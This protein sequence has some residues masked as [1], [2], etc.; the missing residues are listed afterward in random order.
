VRNLNAPPGWTILG[1]MDG[2]V[3]SVLAGLRASGY[4]GSIAAEFFEGEAPA[5]EMGKL[6]RRF[7]ASHPAAI[8]HA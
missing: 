8:L 7:L 1:R 5:T 2:G 4:W 6:H 3:M